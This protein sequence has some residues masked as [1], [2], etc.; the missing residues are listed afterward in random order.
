M[1][2]GGWK[3]AIDENSMVEMALMVFSERGHF[4]FKDCVSPEVS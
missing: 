3:G 1:I 2:N 4:W